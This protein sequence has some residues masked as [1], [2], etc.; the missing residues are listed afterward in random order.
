MMVRMKREKW[1]A[2]LTALGCG[3]AAAMDFADLVKPSAVQVDGVPAG[4]AV[5]VGAD[6]WIR[7]TSAAPLSWITLTWDANL[8]AETKV[9]GGE[10]ERTYGD[11]EWHRLDQPEEKRPR[12]GAMPWYFLAT[13]GS[14]TDGYGVETQPNVFASWHATPAGLRLVLDCRAGSRPVKLGTRTLAACRLVSRKGVANESA[15]AAGREFCRALCPKPRLPSEPIYGYND[16][17]CAY[18]KNTATNFLADAEFICSLV[19]GEKVRPF[20]VVDDGWE[21]G[22]IGAKAEAPGQRWAGVNRHWGMPMDEVAK[23]VKAMGARPGLWYR[24]FLPD[25]GERAIVK[26]PIDP[27]DPALP[28]RMREEIRRFV[29][30]GY[31]LIKIDFIT[32]DWCGRWGFKHGDSPIVRK[33]SA[34]RDETRTSAEVVKG[35]YAVMREAAGERAYIIGCNALDHFAAGLFDL[36]R[37]GDDTSGREWARTRKMGPNTL[38]VRSIHN[39]TFYRADADCFGLS[40]AG[41]IPWKLN[42]QWLDLVAASGTALF[43]SWRRQLAT[44][45]SCAAL[46]RALRRAAKPQPTGEPL[47][48]LETLRPTR[49]RFGN[50]TRTFSWE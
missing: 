3:A 23:R 26:D 39:D 11:S 48:W 49:W 17:Y 29:E 34:W 38:G 31:E 40:G 28:S 35:L 16:W 30:W 43:V 27:T 46:E 12:K 22:S 45:E 2:L 37:T 9:L 24:P 14:R 33:L 32:Y 6:G 42:V 1:L 13:D 20:V 8:G 7:V 19:K 15:F 18:G 47:D 44:P 10:W 5:S 21:L 50:E 25:A 36:Q 4:D 41:K